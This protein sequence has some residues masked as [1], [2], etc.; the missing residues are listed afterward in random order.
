ML[1]RFYAYLQR[2]SVNKAEMRVDAAIAELDEA[3]KV[4]C[5]LYDAM[6]YRPSDM[7]LLRQV[8]EARADY[9]RKSEVAYE[10]RKNLTYIKGTK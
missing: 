5:R 2:R 3:Y 8:T 6:V 7:G 4:F 9:I 10:A 1:K